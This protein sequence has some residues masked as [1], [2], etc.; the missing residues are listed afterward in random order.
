MFYIKKFGKPILNNE[1]VYD[2]ILL[3]LYNTTFGH[4]A[5]HLQLEIARALQN[6]SGEQERKN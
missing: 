2:F 5:G 3:D 6:C 4:G 1:F